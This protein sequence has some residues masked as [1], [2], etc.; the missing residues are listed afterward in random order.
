MT[1][2]NIYFTTTHPVDSAAITWGQMGSLIENF[3]FSLFPLAAIEEERLTTNFYRDQKVFNQHLAIAV[4][5]LLV[6][7]EKV[8]GFDAVR[9]AI[10]LSETEI[11]PIYTIK[12]ATEGLDLWDVAK[13]M[14][15]AVDVLVNTCEFPASAFMYQRIKD[16]I[17]SVKDKTDLEHE[18]VVK[19]MNDGESLYVYNADTHL[20][21]ERL[22]VTHMPDSKAKRSYIKVMKE[23]WLSLLNFLGFKKVV[24]S[25]T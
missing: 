20:V 3:I 5:G 2:K 1:A 9:L 14:S 19:T 16:S 6:Y 12:S 18:I 4:G 22:D 8:G 17:L 25:V 10:K 15:Q 24:A 13:A 7:V 23:I 11:E 21:L